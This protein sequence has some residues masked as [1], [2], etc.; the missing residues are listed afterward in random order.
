MDERR[1][2]KVWS[3]SGNSG[4]VPFILD[5]KVP[6]R[7]V[8]FLV[9]RNLISCIERHQPLAYSEIVDRPIDAVRRILVTEEGQ[10]MG[11]STRYHH[12]NALKVLELV[13][14]HHEEY[15]LSPRGREIADP[16][17]SNDAQRLSKKDRNLFCEAIRE[18]KL[19]QRNFFVLFTGD[20]GLDPWEYGKPVSLRPIS[21]ERT[22]ELTCPNWPGHLRLSKEQTQGIIWG[23]RHWCLA[24]KLVDEIFIRPQVDV[25]PDRANIIFPVSLQLAEK[26]TIEDFDTTLR[27][28]LPLEQPV[29]GDTI[30]ISI[31]L[32]FYRMCPAEQL[33]LKIAKTLLNKWLTKNSQ[34]AFVEAPS[35]V[36]LKHSSVRRG[37]SRLVWEKQE[38]AF[39]Q[40]EGKVFSRLFVSQALWNKKGKRT[41]ASG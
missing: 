38:E 33:P 35:Y 37:P 8:S 22:Y 19:V 29:Y 32:L 36:V 18:C 10:T 41:Y 4:H 31:P 1:H 16:C 14:H 7:Y 21:G 24:L 40:R 11:R 13:C 39:L 20:A 28:Y 2:E 15:I 27:R 12:L 25:E 3:S 6:T 23:L 5:E 34:Y 30:T 17:F 26:M 9:L